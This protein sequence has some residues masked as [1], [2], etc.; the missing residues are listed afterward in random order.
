MKICQLQSSILIPV[1]NHGAN[2]HVFL[3]G[4]QERNLALS[5]P[6]KWLENYVVHVNRKSWPKMT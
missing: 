5:K 2:T 1:L 4:F 3:V 6:Q